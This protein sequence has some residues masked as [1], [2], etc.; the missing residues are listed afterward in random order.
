MRGLSVIF[1]RGSHPSKSV[2]LFGRRSLQHVILAA[3]WRTMR[4]EPKG[5]FQS[6]GVPRF[7]GEGGG[8]V[9]P[10]GGKGS[11]WLFRVP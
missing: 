5:W 9:W 10:R 7:I 11:C 4:K 3:A 2:D 6:H 8:C 1:H